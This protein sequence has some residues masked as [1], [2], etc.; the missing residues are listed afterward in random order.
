MPP[1]RFGVMADLHQ[2]IMHDGLERLQ[3]FMDRMKEEQVDFIIQLGDFC[4]PLPENDVILTIWNQFEGPQYHV[5]G[6]HDMDRNDKQEIQDYLG[7]PSNYYAFDAGTF[8]FIV[9]D[10]NYYMHD[11]QYIDY[12]NGNY[13]AHSPQL[14]YIPDEQLQWLIDD[15]S[16]TDRHTIIFS[17]QSLHNPLEGALNRDDIHAVLV[18]ANQAAGFHKVMACFNGHNHVDACI[19]HDGIHYIEVNSMSNQWLGE[20]YEYDY[21]EPSLLNRRPALKYVAMYQD[22]LYMTVTLTPNNIQIEGIQSAFIGP[23]PL[24][25]GH[26]GI[27]CG[28]ETTAA[29]SH[30]NLKL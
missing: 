13:Y 27:V 5:L 29:I 9:L 6:N 26:S 4:F 16:R 28:Y 1:L 19:T 15:L 10:V 22:P 20:G 17:H 11:N 12:N 7:M 3:V 21:D 8:H 2:D 23:T 24:E 14:P 18:A 30:R 25:R